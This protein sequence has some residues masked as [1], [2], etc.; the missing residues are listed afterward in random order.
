MALLL[1]AASAMAVGGAIWATQPDPVAREDV[2]MFPGLAMLLPNAARIEIVR[3]GRKLILVDRDGAWQ[4]PERAGYPVEPQR[5]HHLL[6]GL[7]ELRLREART[8]DPASARQLGLGDPEGA[9]DDATAIRVWASDGT[10]MA[11][12]IVGHALPGGASLFVRRPGQ[13]QT[14]LADG[15]LAAS[16]DPVD[17]VDVGVVDLASG[18]IARI[19]AT[20]DT[21]MLGFAAVNGRFALVAPAMAAPL[22]PFRLEAVGHAWE[23]LAFTRVVPEIELP[24]VPVGHTVIAMTDGMRVVAGFNLDGRDVWL[25]IAATGGAAGSADAIN[26]HTAGWAYLVAASSL[27]ALLPMLSDLRAYAPASEPDGPPAPLA[28]SAK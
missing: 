24:G 20:R 8:G 4:L 6:T 1:A 28:R 18:G 12:V 15:V 2:A 9:T 5:L 7:S 3:H 26:A 16:A 10:V 17:W 27:P 22:D 21:Q 19:D 13:D 11:A 14:W 23:H 25:T